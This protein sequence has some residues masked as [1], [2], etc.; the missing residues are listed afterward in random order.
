MTLEG[1][2][3]LVSGGSRGIGAAICLALARD[4]ADLAIN[5]RRDDEAARDVQRQAEALGRRARERVLDEHTYVH[6]ARRLLELLDLRVPEP[7]A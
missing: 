5:Y 7:V 6:R 4:G 1:R 2:V 3:A